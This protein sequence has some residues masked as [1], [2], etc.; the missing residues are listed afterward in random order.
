MVS[1]ITSVS[2]DLTISSTVC[3]GTDQRKHQSTAPLD[4]VRGSHRWPLNSRY[5]GQAT[6]K[7]FPFDDV[8]MYWKSSRKFKRNRWIFKNRQTMCWRFTTPCVYSLRSGDAYIC[9]RKL[10]IIGS[11]NGLSPSRHQAIWTRTEILSIG[12]LGKKLKWNLQ[13][14]W[15][16]F[17]QE[18]CIWKC[19]LGNGCHFIAAS[20]C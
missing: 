10:T 20:M 14:N 9:V 16:I 18:K 7:M 2:I 17:I 13:R 4:F 6:R 8:I 11:D 3:S 15:Y 1:Q 12:P 5:K 19:R